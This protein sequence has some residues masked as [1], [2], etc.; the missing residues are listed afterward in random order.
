MYQHVI[1]KEI[2]NSV[3][4]NMLNWRNKMYYQIFIWQVIKGKFNMS[5]VYH[6]ECVRNPKRRYENKKIAV[7]IKKILNKILKNLVINKETL[8]A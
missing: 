8:S 5:D 2:D 1:D 4:K 6:I 7:D 3:E